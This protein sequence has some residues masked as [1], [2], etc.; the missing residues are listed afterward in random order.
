MGVLFEVELEVLHEGL[1]DSGLGV[2]VAELALGLALELGLFEADADDGGEPLA[3]V[4]AAEV[5]GVLLDELALAGVV[6]DGAG[7]PGA[8]ADEVGAAVGGVD[9][10]GEGEGVLVEAGVVLE[11]DLDHCGVGDGLEVE[12]VG[13][14]HLSVL[15][16]LAHEARDAALEVEGAVGLR[17][18][19]GGEGDADGLVE[20]GHLAEALEED[21]AVVEGGA[22]DFAVGEEADVGAAAARVVVEDVALVDDVAGGD[23]A[24]VL[25][26]VDASVAADLDAHMLGE[27][28][29]D[30]RSDAVE[31]AGDLVGAAAELPAGVQRRH[32]RLEGGAPGRRVHVDGDA[33]PVVPDGDGAVGVDA[34]GYAVAVAGHGLVDGVVDDFVDEMVEPA[35]VGAADVHAGPAAHRL[36]ALEHLDVAGCVARL[37]LLY[38]RGERLLLGAPGISGARRVRWRSARPPPPRDSSP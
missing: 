2:G 25:L 22:E 6:V 37:F 30:G 23:A 36:E 7:E 19:F 26:G 12:G 34:D 15:V 10:V 38:H 13:L 14:E 17:V 18:V 16:E 35:L 33:A 11:R 4:V 20:V 32:D 27:R 5:G 3:D 8:E 9:A 24:H 1:L 21:V 28:V 29:D 31:S